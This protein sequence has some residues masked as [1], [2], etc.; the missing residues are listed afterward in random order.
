MV[1]NASSTFCALFAEVSRKEIPTCP[2]TKENIFF[3]KKE[4]FTKTISEFLCLIVIYNFLLN[5]ISFVSN[6]KFVHRLAGVSVNLSQPL[7]HIVETDFICYVIHDDDSVRS[8]VVAAGNGSKSFLSG[9][10]KRGLFKEHWIRQRK[11]LQKQNLITCI[12]NLQFNG[13]AIDFQSSNFLFQRRSPQRERTAILKTYEVDSNGWNIT[14]SVSIVGKSKEKARFSNSTVPNQQQ[15]KQIVAE[16]IVSR[17]TSYYQQIC[18]LV[19]HSGHLLNNNLKFFW[20]P[21]RFFL[22]KKENVQMDWL[23]EIQ[24]RKRCFCLFGTWVATALPHNFIEF[25]RLFVNKKLQH[26]EGMNST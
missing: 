18:L 20:F 5:Q 10:L 15:F 6:Q 19:R 1:K 3:F 24:K 25:P 11:A 7:L 21:L 4:V 13:F 26:K 14:V 17:R 12:P 2:L 16:E 8:S 9:C 22:L 23:F